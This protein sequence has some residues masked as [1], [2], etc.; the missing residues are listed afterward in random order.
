M[1][2]FGAFTYGR[3]Y[4]TFRTSITSCSQ[5][6]LRIF[7]EYG[8]SVLPTIPTVPYRVVMRNG[9]EVMVNNPCDYPDNAQDV[10]E[11]LEPIVNATIIVPLEYYSP[12]TMLC[13][14]YK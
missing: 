14:V 11:E 13:R 4:S 6:I 10:A 8:I 5:K 7:Q 2:V 3:V 1:W 12:I 9:D